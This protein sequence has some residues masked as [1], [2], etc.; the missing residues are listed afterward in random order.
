MTVSYDSVG[1]HLTTGHADER[2]PVAWKPHGPGA[3]TLVVIPTAE[4]HLPERWLPL[5]QAL[6][7]P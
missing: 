5:I 3:V 2:F 6:P 4:K 7:R 1:H